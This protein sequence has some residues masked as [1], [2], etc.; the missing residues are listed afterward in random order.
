MRVEI[1]KQTSSAAE[2]EPNP[3]KAPTCFIAWCS[4]KLIV[5]DTVFAAAPPTLAAS[6]SAKLTVP[7]TVFAAAPAALDA[8]EVSLDAAPNMIATCKCVCERERESSSS[9]SELERR[10]LNDDA[11]EEDLRLARPFIELSGRG[12]LYDV[13]VH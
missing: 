5:P 8:A 12:W 11:V 3:V 10:K 13:C 1:E 4:E 6:C 2:G 7:D 9:S